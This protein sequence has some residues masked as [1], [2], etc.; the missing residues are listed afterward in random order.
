MEV[1]Y[2]KN[3]RN[4][5][6]RLYIW[7]KYHCC[8]SIEQ[9]RYC[10]YATVEEWIEKRKWYMLEW[11]D[12][13]KREIKIGNEW[14]CYQNTYTTRR[15]Y[16]RHFCYTL[17]R[18]SRGN[19]TSENREQIASW[20]IGNKNRELQRAIGS[21]ETGICEAGEGKGWSDWITTC[22]IWLINR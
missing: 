14:I 20:L 8:L 5:T 22:T 2:S 15:S 12:S 11:V 6:I 9:P 13:V 4:W 1:E 3:R 21:R 7:V 17:I 19:I 16:F 18:N 10:R